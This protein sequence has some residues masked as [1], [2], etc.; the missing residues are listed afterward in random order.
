MFE[1]IV[2]SRRVLE[3]AVY[4]ALKEIVD[5]SDGKVIIVSLE[6]GGSFDKA[7]SLQGVSLLGVRSEIGVALSN[8]FARYCR[9]KKTAEFDMGLVFHNIEMLKNECYPVFAVKKKIKK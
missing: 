7:L 8:L 3:K 2:I 5:P 4:N 6:Q 9:S 1:K